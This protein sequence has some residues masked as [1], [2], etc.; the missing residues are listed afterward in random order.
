M[1]AGKEVARSRSSAGGGSGGYVVQRGRWVEERERE[2]REEM[3]RNE[4][5]GQGDGWARTSYEEV[6]PEDDGMLLG[7][8]V[9]W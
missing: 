8:G 5:E 4:K 6:K 1:K 3:N 9:V 2:V 7:S